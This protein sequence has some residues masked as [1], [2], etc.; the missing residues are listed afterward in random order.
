MTRLTSLLNGLCFHV[1]ALQTHFQGSDQ[2]HLDLLR[3]QRCRAMSACSALL[4]LLLYGF[5]EISRRPRWGVLDQP[6]AWS[7]GCL[8][9]C[10]C[11]GTAGRCRPEVN[12]GS[13]RTPHCAFHTSSCKAGFTLRVPLGPSADAHDTHPGQSVLREAAPSSVML[14]NWCLGNQF[15]PTVIGIRIK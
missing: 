3:V 6:G 14:R 8:G 10:C 2:D 9:Q 11:H 7:S 13:R 4:S 15:S 12:T 5:V 1:K